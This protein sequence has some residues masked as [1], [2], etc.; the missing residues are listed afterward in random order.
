MFVS[1]IHEKLTLYKQYLKNDHIFG[2]DLNN[3]NPLF[4][5]NALYFITFIR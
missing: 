4:F 1:L 3:F 5:K 2:T